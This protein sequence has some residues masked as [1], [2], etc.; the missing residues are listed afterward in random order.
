MVV[1]ATSR[2]RVPGRDAGCRVRGGSHVGHLVNS[3]R[4]QALFYTSNKI[5]ITP[6]N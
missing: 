1:I 5:S 6:E 4:T 2:C 3:R